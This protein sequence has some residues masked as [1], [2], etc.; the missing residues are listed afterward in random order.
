MNSEIVIII[1][2]I[3]LHYILID[4]EDNYICPEY[5]EV[6]HKHNFKQIGE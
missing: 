6:E 5:C 4:L 3:L 1:V 2:A